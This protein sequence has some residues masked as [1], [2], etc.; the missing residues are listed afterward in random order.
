MCFQLY[1][2][3]RELKHTSEQYLWFR[4]DWARASLIRFVIFGILRKSKMHLTAAIYGPWILV[5][6]METDRTHRFWVEINVKISLSYHS[7]VFF[8]R[9]ELDFAPD[10]QLFTEFGKYQPCCCCIQFCLEWST[11]VQKFLSWEAAHC[12]VSVWNEKPGSILFQETIIPQIHHFGICEFCI[13]VLKSIFNTGCLDTF[14]TEFFLFLIFYISSMTAKSCLSIIFFCISI[15]YFVFFTCLVRKKKGV[16]NFWDTLY[17]FK[18][19]TK[20]YN[21]F[22]WI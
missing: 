6:S 20:T 12:E 4:V 21:G 22:I 8:C 2:Y 5:T 11:I 1:D 7:A 18:I 10:C 17:K 14:G 16:I 15:I 13:S 9:Q 19:H 3:D